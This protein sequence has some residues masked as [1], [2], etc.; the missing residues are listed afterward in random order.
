MSAVWRVGPEVAWVDGEVGRVAILDLDR[1]QEPAVVLTDTSA[2]IWMCIDGTS[3]DD[4]IV[5]QVAAEYEVNEDEIREQV[6]SFLG[7]LAERH[8]IVRT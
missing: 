2:V 8:L 4:G 3:T 1:L 7:D 6:L 5:T